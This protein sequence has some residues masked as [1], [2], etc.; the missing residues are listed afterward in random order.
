MNIERFLKNTTPSWIEATGE[1][2]DIVISTRIR[3][4]RNL[5]GILFPISFTEEDAKQVD[6]AVMQV[7]LGIDNNNH[8]FS[9]FSMRDMSSL[10]RQVLVEK[11]LISPNLAK[12]E[13]TASVFLTEDEAISVM[14]NEEDHIRIQC[15]SPGMQLI[16]TYEKAK[17]VD[18]YLSKQLAYAYDEQFGYLTSCPTN[19]GTGLRASVMM[20]LP[21]LTMSKQINVLIQMM[22]RLGMV[23]R[24]IY[25]EGSENLGNIYQISNQI[26]LGKSEREILDEL[27][28]VVEQI[29]QKERNARQQ[30]FARAPVALEDRLYRSL[31]TLLYA[32]VLTSEEAATCLSDVRLA[33]DLQIIQHLSLAQL[34]ECM[35]LIKPGIIQQYGNSKL[36]P[37]QRDVFR[38]K[39]LQEK[40]KMQ[41][42]NAPMISEKG[43]DL[44]DV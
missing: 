3:F 29:I 18:R 24:G 15:L 34:N 1:N 40:L 10:Q 17:Q 43:E 21:G 20:H 4:A 2:A 32:R 12:H 16:E 8:H 38:A 7:L 35:L 44:Y 39:L 19:V 5:N 37:E 6:E 30:L 27:Q 36:Q 23:V 42:Q 11:H 13:K 9:Y 33:V 31:G 25:G 41:N 22:T 14:V 28:T 26:T